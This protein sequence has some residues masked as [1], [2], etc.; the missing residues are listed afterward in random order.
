MSAL[1]FLER[2][3][4][5]LDG[6]DRDLR[7]VCD[8]VEF[9]PACPL[10]GRSEKFLA[11]LVVDDDQRIVIA[12]A[13]ARENHVHGQ[14]PAVGLE[15]FLLDNERFPCESFTFGLFR[16]AGRTAMELVD[17]SDA[18]DDRYHRLRKAEA[19]VHPQVQNA[20]KIL[21]WLMVNDAELKSCLYRQPYDA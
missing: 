2:E 7:V 6:R 15:V 21:K 18:G 17:A 20:I 1:T 14:A 16:H 5:D 3:L 13:L 9:G 12:V 11:R 8:P 10:C 4:S 19:L